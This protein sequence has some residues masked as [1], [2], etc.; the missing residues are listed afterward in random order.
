MRPSSFLAGVPYWEHLL[1]LARQDLSTTECPDAMDPWAHAD[2][3]TWLA[4][5]CQL[6]QPRTAP[7]SE[8]IAVFRHLSD[9]TLVART[10][11]VQLPRHGFAAPHRALHLPQ[12]VVIVV[13]CHSAAAH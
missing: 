10:L 13:C 8:H 11:M 2:L 3:V 4:C 6:L 1:E 12:P 5:H 9:P 7:G